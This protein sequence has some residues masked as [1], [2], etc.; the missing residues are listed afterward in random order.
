MK[1][2]LYA[3][4]CMRGGVERPI[5]H[6]AEPSGVLWS[7]DPTLSAI[8]PVQYDLSCFNWFIVYV[9]ASKT[10]P[11]SSAHQM[12]PANDRSPF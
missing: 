5:Q 10:P 11:S 4:N 3:H 12:S 7:R 2:V 9:G 1:G 6:K 8:V